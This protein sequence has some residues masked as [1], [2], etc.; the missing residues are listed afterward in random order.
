MKLEQLK[1]LLKVGLL[2]LSLLVVGNLW[3]NVRGLLRDLRGATENL[4]NTSKEFN[5]YWV[6]QRQVLESTK[7]QK[8]V[9]AALAVGATYQATGRLINTQ[10]IPAVLAQLKSST[11]A[12]D[13]LEGL[14]G[15]GSRLVADTNTRVNQE[16]LPE[17]VAG[18]K[19][20]TKL[21]DG[22]NVI[23]QGTGASVEQ[24]IG[25]LNHLVAMGDVTVQTVN[26][27][28]AD[29]KLEELVAAALSTVRHAD[30][31]T[32]SLDAAAAELP[33][34]VKQARKWQKPLQVAQLIAI[35]ASLFKPY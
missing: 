2:G 25:A 20:V 22:V 18:T 19:S 26:Q 13:R 9:E 32:A 4:R 15:A 16:L 12:T 5:D 28:L 21:V 24:V 7:N 27:R 34:I 6:A 23:A 35:I 17:I 30:G 29:P 14:V 10:V 3:W 33:P 1:D 11:A 31:I 8:A